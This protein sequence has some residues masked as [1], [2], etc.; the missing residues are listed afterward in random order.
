MAVLV[1]PLVLKSQD[2]LIWDQ[3]EVLNCSDFFEAFTC[4]RRVF[5][6]IQ[7]TGGIKCRGKKKGPGADYNQLENQLAAN[8]QID[9]AL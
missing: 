6:K 7:N 1:G 8:H 9:R 2:E 4:G 5:T 3:V